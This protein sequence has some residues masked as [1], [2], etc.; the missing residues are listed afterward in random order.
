MKSGTCPKCR[1][2][3]VYRRA[4]DPDQ[5]EMVT[6][7]GGVLSQGTPPERYVCGACGYVEQYVTAEDALGVV[8]E[9]WERVGR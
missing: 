4:G 2:T 7:S 5:R 3:P 6:I 1:A 9:T 8:R